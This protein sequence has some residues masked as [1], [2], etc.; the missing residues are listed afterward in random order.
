MSSEVIDTRALK[1][2]LGDIDPNFLLNGS[3]GA[4]LEY[5]GKILRTFP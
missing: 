2:A 5:S 3:G 4:F 1:L